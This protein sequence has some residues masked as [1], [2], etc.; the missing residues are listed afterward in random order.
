MSHRK[1]NAFT[2]IELLVVIAI[3][4]ILAAILFPVFAQVRE[5]ARATACLSNTKQIGLA[6]QQYVQD[7]DEHVCMNNDGTWFQQP[8]GSGNYYLNTWMSLLKPYMKADKLWTCPSASESTG[9]Y[10]AYDYSG[11]SPWTSGPLVGS[12]AS[13]YVLNNYYDYDATNGA[14]FQSP[15]PDS[16]AS[17]QM[18]SSLVFCA[19]GGQAPTTAWDPEQI[20]SQGAGIEFDSATKPT[21]AHAVGQYS[22]GAFFGRHLGGGKTVFFD[23]H[24]KFLRLTELTKSVYDAKAGGCIYSYLS[25]AD[26]SAMPACAAG[27]KP[28]E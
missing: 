20:V 16:L 9:L 11:S 7:Y 15:T 19:D 5:K 25:K 4:A 24:A 27:Q 21:N 12:L 6:L 23:G 8:A 26:T 10:A 3:I 28:L 22:Q 1:R 2:L 17:L 18:P 14:V 13:S